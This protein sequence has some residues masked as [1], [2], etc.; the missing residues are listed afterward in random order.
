[1]T[2]DEAIQHAESNAAQHEKWSKQKYFENESWN[3]E[4]KKEHILAAEEQRQFASWLTEL[5]ERRAADVQ[6][7]KY[8]K[9]EYEETIGG[10]KHYHCT[11]CDKG[12][13]CVAD[14]N[15]I[16]WWKFCPKCG[17]DMREVIAN[18]T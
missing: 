14:E 6:P 2:I 8:G 13:E 1:M 17:A 10:M 9:W 16:L 7:V 11:N 12:N 4:S 3:E 18:E 5:K 15:Q